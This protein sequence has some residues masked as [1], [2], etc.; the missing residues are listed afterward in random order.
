VSSSPK[1][2]KALNAQEVKQRK[3]RPKCYGCGKVGHE[4]RDCN[5]KEDD[6]SDTES[7][8]KVEGVKNVRNIRV[9]LHRL[10]TI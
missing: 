10:D 1:N 4:I 6:T 9:C 7:E 3:D 5:N 8:K 2:K